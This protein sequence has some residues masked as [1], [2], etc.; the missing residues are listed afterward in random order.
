MSNSLLD[1]AVCE[2]R[3]VPVGVVSVITPWNVPLVLSMRSVSPAV[4][5]GN[6]VVLD[7][8]RRLRSA[9]GSFGACIRTSRLAFW[10]ARCSAG[11]RLEFPKKYQGGAFI[12]FHGFLESR[13]D[14]ARRLQRNI[15]AVREW[16]ALGQL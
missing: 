11:R 5:L 12:A 15:P 13:A 9:A 16:K 1:P 7:P 8:I 3:R 14:A 2:R 10:P 6:A 4:A